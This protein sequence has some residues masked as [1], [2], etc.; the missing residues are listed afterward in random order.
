MADNRKVWHLTKWQE[1]VGLAESVHQRQLTEFEYVNRSSQSSPLRRRKLS[2]WLAVLASLT[3]MIW[4]GAGSAFSAQPPD[5]QVNKFALD[6]YCTEAEKE[7]KPLAQGQISYETITE[8]ASERAVTDHPDI[9]RT[10]TAWKTKIVAV[11]DQYGDEP[12]TQ[13][14]RED[15]GLNR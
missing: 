15:P 3:G 2:R 6:A 1:P 7:L 12:T 9:Y 13:L 5:E 11:L 10:P 4:I 14:C 8:K